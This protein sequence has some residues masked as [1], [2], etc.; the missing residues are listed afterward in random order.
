MLIPNELDVMESV[1]FRSL[2]PV[3][4]EKNLQIVENKQI[5]NDF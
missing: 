5:F 4:S 2:F 3:T 1:T